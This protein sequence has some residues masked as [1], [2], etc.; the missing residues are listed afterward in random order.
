MVSLISFVVTG[1]LIAA[2]F[3]VVYLVAMIFTH[4][5]T[6]LE[7]VLAAANTTD[8]TYIISCLDI[9]YDEEKCAQ[10]FNYAYYK[11]VVI[12][13]ATVWV[14]I[15]TIVSSVSLRLNLCH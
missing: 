7:I 2:S 15:L 12:T 8:F 3:L 11:S 6:P 14:V 5:R 13:K 1:R 9:Y 10:V 4:N